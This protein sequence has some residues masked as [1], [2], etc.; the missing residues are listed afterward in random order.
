[1][2]RTM[3]EGETQEERLKGVK[4]RIRTT[5][6]E[7]EKTAT[8]QFNLTYRM[9]YLESSDINQEPPSRTLVV[10][11]LYPRILY[12]FSD[13]VCYITTNPKA[14][15]DEISNLLD[16][17]SSGHEWNFNQRVRPGLLIIVN[18]DGRTGDTGRQWCDVDYATK[19]LTDKL[20]LSDRFK[21]L[22]ELWHQ[23]GKEL[24][25]TK[26][27]ILCYYDSFRVVCIPSLNAQSTTVIAAQ[28]EKLYFEIQASSQ[29]LRRKRQL[30]G[31]DLD[32]ESLMLYMNHAFHRLSKGLKNPIDFHYLATKVSQTPTGF[33]GHLVNVLATLKDNQQG[34]SAEASIGQEQR[35]L[36]SVIPY[37]ASSIVLEISTTRPSRNAKITDLV[38]K[39]REAFDH[40]Y[41]H[42]WRCEAMKEVLSN[43]YRCQNYFD[44]HEKGHQYFVY[45]PTFNNYK[46]YSQEVGDFDA[47]YVSK[48]LVRTLNREIEACLQSGDLREKLRLTAQASGMSSITSHR[49]CLVCLSRCPTY[50]LPCKQ[51]QHAVCEECVFKFDGHTGSVENDSIKLSRCPLGCEFTVDVWKTKFKPAAAGAR[52]LSLDGGGVR[53]ILE[54]CIL[55]K[56]IDEIGLGIPIQELFD[57]AIG[58]STGGI[59]ALG[60]FKA[61]WSVEKA[62]T[63]F[64][65]LVDE[66]FTKRHF[67]SI[68][69]FKHAAQVLYSFRYRSDGIENALKGAFGNGFLFGLSKPSRAEL[70]KVGVVSILESGR[71]YL[72]ANY[73][74][75]NEMNGGEG[76]YLLR[77]EDPSMELKTWEAARSTSAAQTYFRP[78]L[79]RPTLRTFTDGAMQQ[80]NPIRIAD[81][82][83]CKI[84]GEEAEK[85]PDIIISVGTG[86]QEGSSQIAKKPNRAARLLLKVTPKGLVDKVGVV[87]DMV[88]STLDCE[89]QWREFYQSINWDEPHRARCHRLNI[90]LRAEP[91]KLDDVGSLIWLKDVAAT[92]LSPEHKGYS[93]SMYTNAHEHVTVV[94]RQ[95]IATLFYFQP[96]RQGQTQVQR[97]NWRG[98]LKCRLSPSLRTQFSALIGRGI[99]FRALEN[100]QIQD[101]RRLS[102]S[103]HSRQGME[104]EFDVTD[105]NNKIYIEV[106]FADTHRTFWDCISGFPR[107]LHVRHI[108]DFLSSSLTGSTD[109]QPESPNSEPDAQTP[110]QQAIALY[111][112]QSDEPGDLSFKKGDI[113]TVT[114][115]TEKAE[116]W[117][118]GRVA[119]RTGDFPRFVG[120]SPS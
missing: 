73:R 1:M 87:Y 9:N 27:L 48:N 64:E 98:R 106:A 69:V 84:W 78:F 94:A 50:V 40:F 88:K 97:C 114:E 118:K 62:M 26:D 68:P 63:I 58:T 93:N 31:M 76:D 6:E 80:N 12:T 21:R 100:G 77:E 4:A 83:R 103:F 55:K 29:K 39:C 67:L 51:V 13:V 28:F 79:H 102:P 57:V 44:G 72:L 70:V 3:R 7:H 71:S 85:I 82:E 108:I 107:L 16:W 19:T 95:L 34:P 117:W 109:Q 18:K 24:E 46:T 30:V 61:N 90:G 86:L 25:T 41:R 33:P 8:Q 74:R 105:S 113:I 120:K 47:S 11:N 14:T 60:L 96:G 54:L 110:E 10:R 23:R 15:E 89:R 17:A 112:F 104:V 20:S 53:G 99:Q 38:A 22:Q 37:L 36:N 116:D 42:H 49:T 115:K 5:L 52:V 101:I 91:P 75:T 56:L 32:V 2:R 66:A 111:G 43:Y 92:Y 45:T 65:G 59:I 81:G 119:G 35:L